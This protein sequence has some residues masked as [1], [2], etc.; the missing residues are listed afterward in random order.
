MPQIKNRPNGVKRTNINSPKSFTNALKRTKKARKLNKT[1]ITINI[2]AGGNKQA[3]KR[4]ETTSN[5]NKI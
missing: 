1:K 3:K 4:N 5:L 2:I